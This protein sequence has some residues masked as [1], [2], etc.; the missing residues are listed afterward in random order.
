M[1]VILIGLVILFV[2][3]IVFEWG[4]DYLGL[5]G[6][7]SEVLGKV[8]G[9]PISYQEF[10]ERVRIA[11]DQQKK[12]D[13]ASELDETQMEQMRE[14]EWERIV[15]DLLLEKEIKRLGIEVTDQEIRDWVIDFPETLPDN[16]RRIFSDSSGTLNRAYL[17]QAI[18][19]QTPEVKNFWLQ[20]ESMLRQQRKLEKLSSIITSS[21]RVGDGEI[22]QRFEDQEIQVTANYVL[23][24]PSRFVKDEEA[25]PTESEIKQYYDKH[26]HEFK[27][28]AMRKLKYI[29]ISD[30][31]SKQDSTDVL[32]TMEQVL[33]SSK[34]GVD[35]KSLIDMYSETK[36]TEAFF[37][38][39]ELS[40]VKEEALQ[41]AKIGDIVGP[42]KDVDGFHLMKILETRQGKDEFVKASHI[43]LQ[44]TN[45]DSIKTLAEE[46]YKR[47]KKGEDFGQLA[48]TYSKDPGS[49]NQG[50]QLGWFGKGRMIKA[51]EEAAFSGKV[52]EVVGPVETSYGQH[53]IKV[54]AK[55]KKE[56]RL[57]DIKMT[58]KV[59]G[60]TQDALLKGAQ[61]FAYLAKSGNFED[62]AKVS[63]Y[64]VRE[65]PPFA[66]GAV[67]PGI[68]VNQGISRFAFEGSMGD[69]SEVFRIQGGYVV[70]MLSEVKKEGPSPLDEVKET[71]K[72]KVMREKKM[73]KVRTYCESIRAKIKPGDS[74]GAVSTYDPN[75]GVQTTTPFTAA[76]IVPGVGRDYAFI[77]TVF[78]LKPGEISRPVE[79]SRGYYLIQLVNKTALDTTAYKSR[80]QALRDRNTFITNWMTRLKE[81]AKIVDNR[82][83]YFR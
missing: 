66:R 18:D 61:D 74:L 55:D 49:A 15:Q 26:V 39:G 62:E 1:P 17:Q 11:E 36:S 25:Q 57:G 51:F 13:K 30:A 65:T 72:A 67:I 79:G 48:K 50:G 81:N 8:D 54:E 10:N 77:G 3:M 70:C 73:E 31:P 35:F 78:V 58:V 75:L 71:V 68:G 19:A 5:R 16:I 22:L 24:D 7:R 76:G 12:Q 42:I 80:S 82:D 21:V 6:Q 64:D 46:I 33:S 34:K 45:K 20:V 63:K 41:T 47:A 44:G 38:H 37:K 52:G 4:M 27:K 23:F 2:V 14:R 28:P 53:I 40:P 59:T 56:V 43:L 60:Q 83:L 32:S 69:I 9:T 29:L